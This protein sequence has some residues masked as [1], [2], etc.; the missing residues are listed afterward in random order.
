MLIPLSISYPIAVKIT[1]SIISLLSPSP[2]LPLPSKPPSPL[3]LLSSRSLPKPI[4]PLHI[5]TT[6]PSRPLLPAI[7]PGDYDI[8]ECSKYKMCEDWVWL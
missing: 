5:P 4:R 1:P 2:P 6:Y 3:P 8:L 7:I